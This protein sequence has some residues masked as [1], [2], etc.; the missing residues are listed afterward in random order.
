M[1]SAGWPPEPEWWQVRRRAVPSRPWRSAAFSSSAACFSSE[2][3]RSLRLLALSASAFGAF[4][5]GTKVRFMLALQALLFGDQQVEPLLLRQ[6]LAI[7]RRSA[8]VF[9]RRSR[10]LPARVRTGRQAGYRSPDA[11]PAPPRRAEWRCDRCERVVGLDQD[12]RRRIEPHALQCAEHLGKHAAPA[13]QRALDV[14][15]LGLEHPQS[16]RDILDVLAELA[17][18]LRRLDKRGGNRRLVLLDRRDF[19]CQ[20]LDPLTR[21]ADFAG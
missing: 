19:G 6:L 5:L 17:F 16:I 20:R 12:G 14:G 10:P 11:V 3:I 13:R 8:S 7:V 18:G 1:P 9:R 4:A 21:K 2:A 15:L